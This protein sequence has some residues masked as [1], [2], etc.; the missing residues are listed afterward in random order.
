MHFGKR[1]RK[2]RE[3]TGKS[4]QVMAAEFGVNQGTI[5][6]L[7]RRPKHPRGEM[8]EKLAAYYHVPETYF[9]DETLP[10]ILPLT[11]QESNLVNALRRR[12]IPAML[13]IIG[14]VTRDIAPEIGLRTSDVR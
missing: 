7:E 5:S 9:F 12:D 8:L 3:R 13:S 14:D 10:D 6:A 1:L 11:E 4:Q 2:L